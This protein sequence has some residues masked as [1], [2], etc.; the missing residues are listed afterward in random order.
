MLIETLYQTSKHEEVRKSKNQND[1]N[2]NIID[3]TSQNREHKNEITIQKYSGCHVMVKSNPF[4]CTLTMYLL[5]QYF[6][7]IAVYFFALQCISLR[8]SVFVVHWSL[9]VFVVYWSLCVLVVY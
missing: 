9:C 1:N 5:L 2:Q 4:G 8:C 3:S 7:Y 6:W